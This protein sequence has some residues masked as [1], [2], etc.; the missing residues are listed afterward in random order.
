MTRC[1]FCEIAAKARDPQM[2]VLEDEHVF[3]LVSLQQKPGH[4]GH[5]LA[6]SKRH[7]P[8]I[9]ELP[10]DLHAPLLSALRRV[11]RAVKAAFA[12]DGIHIRQNNEAAAGQDVFHLHFHVIPRYDGDQF[13]AQPYERLP[14]EV[15]AEQARTL[16]DTLLQDPA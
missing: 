12:A 15:R 4:H 9:Y 10:S 11:S 8:N 13:D 2:I 16:R 1:V 5:A 14:L 7:V 6:V 3:A